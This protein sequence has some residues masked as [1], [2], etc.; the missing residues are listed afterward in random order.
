MR[1][2]EV[3]KGGRRALS[4]L[5][6]RMSIGRCSVAQFH[7]HPHA[8][9]PQPQLFVYPTVFCGIFDTKL[10]YRILLTHFFLSDR[11]HS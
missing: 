9:L 3:E 2:V 5:L 1:H 10:L 4:K 11:R 6:I 8:G 7:G